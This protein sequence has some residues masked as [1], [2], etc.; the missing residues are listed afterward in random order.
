MW[1]TTK[2]ELA[3]RRTSK[4][5]DR[6]SYL[7]LLRDEH[8][9][10]RIEAAVRVYAPVQVSPTPYKRRKYIGVPHHRRNRINRTI[11]KVGPQPKE[12]R[13]L[14]SQRREAPGDVPL[15]SREGNAAVRRTRGT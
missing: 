10:A 11:P 9:V 7:Y 5:I 15:G 8:L 13:V 12:R 4:K 3:F 1:L 6:S 2:S 14:E